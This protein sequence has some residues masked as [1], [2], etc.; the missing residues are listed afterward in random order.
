MAQSVAIKMLEASNKRLM[1]LEK[2]LAKKKKALQVQE[3]LFQSEPKRTL[4]D[5]PAYQYYQKELANCEV[6]YQRRLE[7]LEADYERKCRF[8]QDKI[9]E[10]KSKQR[11]EQP[12]GKVY[13]RLKAEVEMEQKEYDALKAECDAS[14]KTYSEVVVPRELEA[15]KKRALAEAEAQ[16]RKEEL[17]L[18]EKRE[19]AIAARKAREAADEARQLAALEEEQKASKP[20]ETISRAPE[21]QE[22]AKGG[23]PPSAKIPSSILERIKSAPNR[24]A[25]EA[26]ALRETLNDEEDTLWNERHDFFSAQEDEERAAP[27]TN[28]IVSEAPVLREQVIADA[29]SAAIANDMATQ[30]RL[31]DSM[32]TEEVRE[33]SKRMASHYAP[34]PKAPPFAF[35]APVSGVEVPAFPPLLRTTKKLVVKRPGAPAVASR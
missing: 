29:V 3:E 22:I 19:A 5:L 18:Q 6:V 8:F 12:T 24:E 11:E 28:S 23:N 17:E 31:I 21:K 33:Y 35:P 34:K 13:R 7:D 27:E 4:E 30:D 10:L 32:T 25:L 26:I 2:S 20:L 15:L 14:A 1:T 9:D 16:K